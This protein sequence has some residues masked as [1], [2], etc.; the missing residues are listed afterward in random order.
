MNPQDPPEKPEILQLT[1]FGNPILRKVAKHLT[2]NEIKSEKIKRLIKDMYYTLDRKKYGVGLAAPQVGEPLAISA[3]HLQP[4]PW[5]PE[6]KERKLTLINPEIIETHGRRTGMWEGCISFCGGQKE[7]PYAKALRYKK[8]TIKYTDEDG[9]TQKE[10]FEGLLGHVIQHEV[11]HLNGILFV[12]RVKDTT[13]YVT[14]SEYDKRY[15]QM[16]KEA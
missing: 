10:S 11:D 1:Q 15:R 9:K 8:V 5:R 7:F 12:D 3:I 14:V 6:A 2:R 16:N 13:S 4:L